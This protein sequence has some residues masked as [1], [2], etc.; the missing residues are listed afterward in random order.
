ML[1]DAWAEGMA[2]AAGNNTFK[3]GAGGLTK[4]EA[5]DRSNPGMCQRKERAASQAAALNRRSGNVSR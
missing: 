4:P 1:A 5:I 3:R 2:R